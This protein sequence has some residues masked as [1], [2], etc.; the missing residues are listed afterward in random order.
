MLSTPCPAYLDFLGISL[1]K[2]RGFVLSAG[3]LH[4]VHALDQQVHLLRLLNACLVLLLQG[5]LQVSV[6]PASGNESQ[7]ALATADT[8][9]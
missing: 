7:A 4:V 2:E 3:P 5:F 6:Q 1:L 9:Q 8:V